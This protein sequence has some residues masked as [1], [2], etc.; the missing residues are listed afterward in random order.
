VKILAFAPYYL[1]WLMTRFK[2]L[3]EVD[4]EV[5]LVEAVGDTPEVEIKYIAFGQKAIDKFVNELLKYAIR[6]KALKF[7]WREEGVS[8]KTVRKLNNALGLLVKK[9]DLRYIKVF[10]F[11]GGEDGR[12]IYLYLHRDVRKQLRKKAMKILKDKE[13]VDITSKYRFA[14]RN[15]IMYVEESD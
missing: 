4:G 1:N 11:A 3:V 6:D 13:E 12:T 8:I 2:C 15:G 5:K 10:P 14:N 9:K 7:E